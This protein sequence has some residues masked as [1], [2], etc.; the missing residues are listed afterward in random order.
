V[1]VCITLSNSFSPIFFGSTLRFLY[2]L[3]GGAEKATEI[4]TME[5]KAV[6]TTIVLR[7]MLGMVEKCFRNENKEIIRRNFSRFN[8]FCQ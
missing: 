3:S 5:I 8:F 2:F 1:N 4:M 6:V 7:G